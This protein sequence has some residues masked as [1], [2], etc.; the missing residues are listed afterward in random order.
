MGLKIMTDGRGG[1]RDTWYA[2]FTRNGQKVN[3]PLRVPIR[4]TLP[5]DADGRIDLAGEGDAAFERSRRAALAALAKMQTAAKTTGKTEA[6]RQAEDA[7]LVNRYH[8]ARTGKGIESPKLSGLFELWQGLARNYEPTAERKRIAA[9]TFK[10]FEKFARAH[11]AEIGGA[12]DTLDEIT[13]ELAAAWFE[14]LRKV[15][16]WGTVKDQWHLVSKA[17][18]RWHAY[19]GRN[20]FEGVVLR[21]GEKDGAKVERRPLTEAELARLFEV[22]EERPALR[23]LVVCAACTGM[24]LGDVC[25]LKWS[26]IDLRGGV[27]DCITAKA[28]VRVTIPIFARLR[29]VL[30][31]REAKHAVD[32]SPFVFP[33]AA[34]KYNHVNGSG[35]PDQRTGL[36]RMVK[37]YFA[38]AVF[39]EE[40]PAPARLK[41]EKPLEAAAV[42]KLIDGAR[43]APGKAERLR[44]VYARYRQGEQCAKIAEGMG[45]ARGQVSNYLKELEGI[46]GEVYRPRVEG[47]RSRGRAPSAAELMERTR[48]R[49][50]VGKYSASL[51]GWHNLRHTFVVLAIQAGVPAEKVRK[52]VGHGDV[53]TTLDNYFNPTKE[54]EA[55][56]VRKQMSGTVL[57][58]GAARQL[59][60]DEATAEAVMRAA[61]VEADADPARAVLLLLAAMP[62][63]ARE[64]LI[65]ASGANAQRSR[66][67]H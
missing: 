40:E 20:P 55:E 36:V 14:E 35:Y 22:T 64:K 43:F 60:A 13:P 54:S 38:R 58:G 4:G 66:N 26:D 33:G 67:N 37:P 56:R 12:C 5:L 59:T 31:E 11:S 16:A 62:K 51:L 8:R 28:G 46:T 21:R 29:A 3:V 27:I 48:Q 34:A 7:D 42:A 50:K 23:D 45:I 9:A 18:T 10:R 15:Y 44:E 41:D 39:V 24:R 17:W 52:I 63:A 2:R 47:M 6:V 1:Y 30:E 53:E 25:N 49:R 19:P 32:D 57:E 65:R 61:G